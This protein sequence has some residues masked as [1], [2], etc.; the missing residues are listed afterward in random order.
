M[1]MY[2]NMISLACNDFN[3]NNGMTRQRVWAFIIKN[4]EVYN[5][6]EFLTSINIAR[7]EGKIEFKDGLIFVQ[8]AVFKAQFEEAASQLGETESNG[9][10]SVRGKKSVVSQKA[11]KG[12]VASFKSGQRSIVRG[13]AS[14]VSHHKG[15]VSTTSKRGAFGGNIML[16]SSHKKGAQSVSVVRQN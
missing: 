9:K 15:K 10:A 8:P 6:Y 2:L 14:V 3:C 16:T 4:F 13:Q 12:S 5:Y 11:G 7:A 1:N